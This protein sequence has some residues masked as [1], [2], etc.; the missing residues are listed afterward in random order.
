[1]LKQSLGDP[2]L[3]IG[4]DRGRSLFGVIYA[5]V[6]GLLIAFGDTSL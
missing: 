6:D 4:H 1:M 3:S 2:A 5:N